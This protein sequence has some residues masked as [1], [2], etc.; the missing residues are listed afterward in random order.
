MLEGGFKIEVVG[1]VD[2]LRLGDILELGM[3]RLGIALAL[4]ALEGQG[5]IMTGDKVVLRGGGIGNELF[6]EVEL[7]I[8]EELWLWVVEFVWSI[9]VEGLG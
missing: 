8:E 6:W 5:V 7:G 1:G 2:C 9:V 4:E 3:L